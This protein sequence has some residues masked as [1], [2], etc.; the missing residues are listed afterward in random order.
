MKKLNPSAIQGLLKNHNW[1]EFAIAF[2]FHLSTHFPT[3]FEEMQHNTNNTTTVTLPNKS[4]LVQIVFINRIKLSW[5]VS[6][7]N[8]VTIHSVH[9]G[10]LDA[11]EGKKRACDAKPA[12]TK[13]W[14]TLQRHR[15]STD[16]SWR[17]RS[18]CAVSSDKQM[19]QKWGT[20][21]NSQSNRR[22]TGPESFKNCYKNT[23]KGPRTKTSWAF[24]QLR[25]LQN[26]T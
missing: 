18:V 22:I 14:V 15:R 8:L 26:P 10:M 11:A 24:N 19:R 17:W 7:N 9:Q 25:K 12:P 23:P 5:L 6:A 21:K 3:E 16:G 4:W 2:R 13:I 1:T 20:D